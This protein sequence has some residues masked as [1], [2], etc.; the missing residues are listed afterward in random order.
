MITKLGAVMHKQG[1][2]AQILSL[3]Y[4]LWG[5]ESCNRNYYMT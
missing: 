5:K 2:C 4:I 1:E 3:R